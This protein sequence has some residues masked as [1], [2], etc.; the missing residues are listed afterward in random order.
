M[1]FLPIF[2]EESI[3][4]LERWQESLLAIESGA[5]GK[6]TWNSMF[7]T[8]HTIK[9]SSRVVD[10]GRL[11]A[12][13]HKV[14][15]L[16]NGLQ[17]GKLLIN[18]DTITQLFRSYDIVVAWLEK[19][20]SCGGDCDG[21]AQQLDSEQQIARLVGNAAPTSP[22]LAA[23][24]QIEQSKVEQSKVE[25]SIEATAQVSNPSPHSA[26]PP[27]QSLRVPAIRIDEIIRTIGEVSTQ[28]AALGHLIYEELQGRSPKATA[29]IDTLN[30]SLKRMRELAITLRLEPLTRFFSRMEKIA[31]DVSRAQE[32][33]LIIDISG[34]DI[35]LDKIVAER[36]VDPFIHI[37]RNAVDHG[38]ES[39]A[40]R[41][42]AGKSP[43][44]T[45]RLSAR[46]S[47]NSVVIS[48][49]EDGRGLDAN[50]IR[51]KAL[52]KGLIQPT[53]NLSQKDLVNLILQPGF[54][55]AEKV[56]DISGRGVGMDVVSSAIKELG[57]DLSID[58]QVGR[59]T[60]F[61][62]TLPASIA[63]IETFIIEIGTEKFAVPKRDAAAV[64]ELPRTK[65][66]SMG[67]ADESAEWRGEL[68]PFID[69]REFFSFSEQARSND[70]LQCLVVEVNQRQIVVGVGRVAWEQEIVT[71]KVRGGFGRI[72]G[73]NGTT[74]LANGEPSFVLDLRDLANTCLGERRTKASRKEGTY[75]G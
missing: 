65:I 11:G 29:S 22:A 64:I 51:K 49:S 40:D 50:K 45:L 44:G 47:G 66:I 19:V 61:S 17:Q 20:R 2:L 18:K 60:T 25:Q 5:S 70:P 6:D 73:L 42:A 34:R 74:I 30:V 63:I 16:I 41:I 39:A 31:R 43:D 21:P 72:A 36:I 37:V 13:V 4:L 9:G 23:P 32:K 7:R 14:E 26:P 55:T 35:E 71:S 59:G 1:D 57:G 54:S 15:D 62:I 38:L 58:T 52:E 53:D 67:L 27:E 3:E 33:T 8:V 28:A 48:V 68:L 12:Y 69:L 46:S 10:L 75:A 24:T 56:T